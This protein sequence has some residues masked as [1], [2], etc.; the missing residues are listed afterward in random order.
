MISISFSLLV[1]NDIKFSD[2]G[3]SS[4]IEVS[5]QPGRSYAIL[6]LSNGEQIYLNDSISGI[7]RE[8]NNASISSDTNLQMLVYTEKTAGNTEGS[9]VDINTIDV[10]RGGEYVVKLSDGTKVWINSDTK[11]KY[12]VKFTSDI[13]EVYVKGEAFF[14]VSKEKNKRPFIVHTDD[15]KIEVTG[16]KFNVRNYDG[17][18]ACAVLVNGSINMQKNGIVNYLSPGQEACLVDGKFEINDVNVEDAVAWRYG[19]FSFNNVPL[20]KIMDELARWYNLA[21]F[22]T[23]S[24]LE[25]LAFTAWFRRN[26]TINEIIN[27]LEKTREIKV[28]LNRNTLIIEKLQ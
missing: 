27:I 28:S 25:N 1:L 9:D 13:R 11:L 19:A 16:T 18:E 21:I 6:K 5:I 10:P 4:E 7:I 15:F 3:D 26:S 2:V 22:Y 14:E 17:E 8:N 12:P 23:T 24:D 20:G